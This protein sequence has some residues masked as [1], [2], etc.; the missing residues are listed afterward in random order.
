MQFTWGSVTVPGATSE[1]VRKELIYQIERISHH[2]SVV[3]LDG[4]NECKP[5]G[6]TTSFVMTT[7]AQTDDSRAVWPSSPGTG[8][9]SGVDRLTARANGKPLK[10]GVGAG[11]LR[12]KWSGD[13]PVKMPQESHGG[14]VGLGGGGAGHLGEGRPTD[15]S[16]SFAA[17]MLIA[18]SHPSV[19]GQD[20][21][22]WYKS[23]FGCVAWSSFESMSNQLPSE[24]VFVFK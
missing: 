14:Y 23:E 22:G 2:A 10:A 21:M 20:E 9:A 24:S 16:G 1:T 6:L 11:T 18:N 17:S 13:A 19:T 3:I 7:V 5:Q 12:P 15:V 8:W 4:C